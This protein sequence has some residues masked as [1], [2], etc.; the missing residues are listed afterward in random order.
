M[1]FIGKTKC[2]SEKGL[3][4]SEC[5]VVWDFPKKYTF[6]LV[7]FSHLTEKESET[8]REKCFFT[9]VFVQYKSQM[10]YAYVFW[11]HFLVYQ[12]TEVDKYVAAPFRAQ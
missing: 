3:L 1:I 10:F 4:T 6:I 11:N 5:V 12:A 7:I 8:E 2:T 9:C